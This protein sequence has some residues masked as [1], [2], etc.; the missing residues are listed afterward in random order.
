MRTFVS[1]LGVFRYTIHNLVAHPLMEVLHLL[2]LGKYGEYLHQATLPYE[3][4]S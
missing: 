2:G 3:D 4:E 1:K